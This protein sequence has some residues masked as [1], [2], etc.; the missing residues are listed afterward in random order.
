MRYLD[1]HTHVQFAAFDN[2]R[3]E[4]IGRALES[5]VGLVNVGTQKDTSAAA[6]KLAADYAEV[7]AAVG[8]HPIHTYS[9]YHDKKELGAGR[10]F[11]SREER[12]DYSYYRNLA[13]ADK[14]VAIGECGLDYFRLPAEEK[15]IKARQREVFEEQIKLALELKKPLMVHCRPSAK[16]EDAYLDLIEIIKP[17][18]SRLSGFVAH[19]FAGSLETAKQLAELGAYFTFGGVITFASDYDEILKYLPRDRI[20]FETDAP[21]VA[22]VPYRGKRNEPSYVIEVYKAAARLLQVEP[23]RLAE[24]IRENNKAVFGI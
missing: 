16:S 8:L 17:Y 23:K 7:F 15:E 22:P 5:G 19:F 14:V 20:L 11:V 1:S 9:T 12:F 3:K 13:Q 6:A 18:L 2:D 21:Y 10:G 4:V 24:T